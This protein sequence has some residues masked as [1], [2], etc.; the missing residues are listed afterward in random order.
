MG[1]AST[2]AAAEASPDASMGQGPAG[3]G[4]GQG[5]MGVLLQGSQG[6]TGGG[7]AHQPAGLRNNPGGNVCLLINIAGT[8]GRPVTD[9]LRFLYGPDRAIPARTGS[10]C[11]D[12]PNDPT[13][14]APPVERDCSPEAVP[15]H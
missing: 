4:I 14:R 8:S 12:P 1:A 10:L 3:V 9:R 5:G 11:C 6:R 13:T 2:G 7:A 15:R